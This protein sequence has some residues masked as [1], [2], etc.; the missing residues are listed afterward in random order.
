M[1]VGWAAGK[2]FCQGAVQ[3]V[4]LTHDVGVDGIR[5]SGRASR[6]DRGAMTFLPIVA[7]ELRVASRRRSTYWVRTGAALTIVIL[8][9]WCFLMMRTEGATEISQVLFGIMTGGAVIYS[10]FSGVRATADCLSEEKREGTLGLLF[11]TDL[12]GYD[13][14]LGKLAATSLKAFYSVLAIVPMLGVPLLM[15][16]LTLAEF[17]RMA[18]VVVNTLFFS[19]SLGI[20]VSS[21]SRSTKATTGLTMLLLLL[22]AGV[23]PVIGSW[24]ML[25]GRGRVVET[26]WMLP[27]PGFTYFRAWDTSYRIVQ[28]EFWLSLGVIHGLGWF[29]LVLAALIVPRSWQ[30][31]PA[32]AKRLR[33]RER[34][35]LWCYG[36]SGE[37]LA[38]RR[39]LLDQ[40]AIFWLAS[41]TR[42][43]PAFLWGG[44]GLLACGW[45][46]GLAKLGR[47]W[48]NEGVH[49]MTALTL[50]VVIKIWFGAEAGRQLAEDRQQGT[51]EL[52]LS[53][54]LTVQDFVTGHLLALMRVFLGPVILVLVCFVIFMF[55]PDSQDM[56]DH[57]LWIMFWF[58]LIAMLVADL[59]AIFWVGLWQ[60][61]TAPS[62][63]KASGATLSRV[64][65]LP[66]IVIAGLSLFIS[67]AAV[68]SR[69]GPGFGFFLGMWLVVGVG[70][71]VV[72]GLQA[73][74]NFMRRFRIMAAQRYAPEKGFWKRL[75][76]RQAGGS[77]MP[78]VIQPEKRG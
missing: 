51:L 10:L 12:K 21:M 7:R 2:G 44:L 6:G 29:F 66:W 71:D 28:R 37:R 36:N 55:S 75:F 59:V 56:S 11:L 22:F 42:L 30:D 18:L 67:L 33:W 76:G 65:V 53:T 24:E 68:A 45:A 23:P 13:V 61:V 3:S 74:E 46:F 50:N 60:G 69:G 39:R 8:G 26:L 52:Q 40:N 72:Y 31:R 1:G 57:G 17:G 43:K 73:R 32:G 58:C 47:E 20:F 70:I 62:P 54:A 35:A 9:T 63:Q 16:G 64:L 77:E 25:F 19:L 4:I 34:W 5:F 48:L 14:V 49:V 15:G 78:P 27:S 38:F 41:R